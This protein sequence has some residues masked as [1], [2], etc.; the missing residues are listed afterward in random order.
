VGKWDNRTNV[1]SD[2]SQVDLELFDGKI[3]SLITFTCDSFAGQ[4]KPTFFYESS[5]SVFRFEWMTNMTCQTSDYVAVESV[6]GGSPGGW[7]ALAIIAAMFVGFGYV[8]RASLIG[9]CSNWLQRLPAPIASRVANYQYS[10]LSVS[11]EEEEED[12]LLFGV[13]SVEDSV[14]PLVPDNLV[15]SE[16][17]GVPLDTIAEV[18]RVPGD[19]LGATFRDDPNDSDEDLLV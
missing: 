10:R 4:S 7:I 2:G 8:K 9:C 16:L 12:D 13:E 5:D 11:M 14:F 6:S 18:V 3:K 1:Y 15:D 17:S 19:P